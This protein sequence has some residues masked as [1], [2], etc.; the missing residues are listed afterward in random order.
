MMHDPQTPIEK[1]IELFKFLYVKTPRFA[2]F[3]DFCLSEDEE[4]GSQSGGGSPPSIVLLV[5][6]T[7]LYMVLGIRVPTAQIPATILQTLVKQPRSMRRS[8]KKGI[9][10][11]VQLITLPKRAADVVKAIH[12]TQISVKEGEWLAAIDEMRTVMTKTDGI[13]L[14]KEKMVAATNSLLKNPVYAK[15][16]ER[17]GQFVHL[18][19]A[20]FLTE[21][22]IGNAQ[23]V[24]QGNREQWKPLIKNTATLGLLLLK[25]TPIRGQT[26]LVK[27][28]QG[29]RLLHELKETADLYYEL[30]GIIHDW[31]EQRKSNAI[32]A[33]G[34]KNRKTKK[35]NPPVKPFS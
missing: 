6:L 21:G 28:L 35:R 13:N 15:V 23:E 9:A 31:V 34:G 10:Q 3:I 29:V 4:N 12:N 18:N 2:V 22:I 1:F 33:L 24:G 30:S 17:V 20:Y 26:A 14:W 32:K 16:F 5:F 27:S 7:W 19:Q 11:S 8:F 25:N